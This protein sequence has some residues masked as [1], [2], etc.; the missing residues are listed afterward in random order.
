MH[1]RLPGFLGPAPLPLLIRARYSVVGASK[2]YL[3]DRGGV[4]E[5]GARCRLECLVR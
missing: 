4:K 3:R 2:S 5:Q 1:N